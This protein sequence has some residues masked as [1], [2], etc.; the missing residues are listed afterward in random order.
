MVGNQTAIAISDVWDRRFDADAGVLLSDLPGLLQS[1]AIATESN[2]VG[3]QMKNLQSNRLGKTKQADTEL[4]EVK[5]SRI[6]NDLRANHPERLSSTHN[7]YGSVSI[8]L[9]VSVCF[10][11]WMGKP[12]TASTLTTMQTA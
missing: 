10:P 4:D 6:Q 8:P 2:A 1:H 12:G 7:S 9:L 5:W 3:L 11:A